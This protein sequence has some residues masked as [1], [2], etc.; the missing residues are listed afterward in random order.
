MMVRARLDIPETCAWRIL[1]RSN[2]TVLTVLAI[3]GIA[4]TPNPSSAQ[5]AKW[6]APAKWL[7]TL[8]KAEPGTLLLDADGVEFRSAKFRRR[9]NYVEIHTFDLSDR[10]LTLLTYQNRPWH[11]PG[12]RPFRFTLAEPMP[13]EIAAQFTYRVEKPVRNGMPTSK[14]AALAEIPAHHRVWSG[15]SNGTLRLKD[16]GIEYVT[17]NGRDSRT[18][19]W[20]DIQTIANPEPYEFRIMGYR[21]IVE[22]DLKQ[23]LARSIFERLWDRLYA[24]GLNVSPS[25]AGPQVRAHEETRR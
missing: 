25:L 11:E 20:A 18:W 21:E 3:C 6:Q 14:T 1:M 10:E 12:E 22:F 2:L 7:R 17:G 8:K 5:T 13:P 24:T 15:G 9:W 16:D 19:R 4:A 23:P